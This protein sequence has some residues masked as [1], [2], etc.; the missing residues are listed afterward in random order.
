MV[1]TAVINNLALSAG[2]GVGLAKLVLNAATTKVGLAVSVTP[3]GVDR[4]NVLGVYAAI[5]PFDM[6]ATA[7]LPARIGQAGEFIP[8]VVNK[9]DGVVATKSNFIDNLGGFLYVWLDV[10]SGVTGNITVQA[11]EL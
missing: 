6:A 1:S 11:V 9:P 4:S 8:I 7:D 2:Q 5:L 3:T 10:P